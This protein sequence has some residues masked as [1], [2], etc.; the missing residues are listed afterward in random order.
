MHIKFIRK[1]FTAAQLRGMTK[2]V[3]WKQHSQSGS[4]LQK[5]KIQRIK[6]TVSKIFVSNVLMY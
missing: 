3:Q 4:C 2:L 5:D 1:M 6:G